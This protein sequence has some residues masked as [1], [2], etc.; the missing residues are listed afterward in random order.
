MKYLEKHGYLGKK[1]AVDIGA[2]IGTTCLPL[3]QMTSL[4]ILAIEPIPA[5]YEMLIANVDRNS[6][7]HRTTCVKNAVTCQSGKID[8]VFNNRAYGESEVIVNGLERSYS[9]DA[10]FKEHLSVQSAPLDKILSEQR[11]Q[12]NQVAFV[13]S[14][15]EGC[16]TDVIKT[17]EKLWKNNVPLYTELYP[18]KLKSHG[19]TEEFVKQAMQNFSFL[20]TREELALKGENTEVS[21]IEKLRLIIDDLHRKATHSDVLLLPGK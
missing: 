12:A 15:T 8:I 3:A 7:S 1:F 21:P 18:L 2:N 19:G 14:D 10:N 9:T 20:I 5:A 17:G 11:I 4:N 6:F 16:E 13:W